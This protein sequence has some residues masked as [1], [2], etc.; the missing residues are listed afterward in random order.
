M[1]KSEIKLISMILGLFFGC[2]NIIPTKINIYQNYIIPL[3]QNNI[4]PGTIFYPHIR[5]AIIILYLTIIF[6]TILEGY[7]IYK[8]EKRYNVFGFWK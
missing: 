8:Y 7:K 1:K 5:T 6:T 3:I 2:T 4:E